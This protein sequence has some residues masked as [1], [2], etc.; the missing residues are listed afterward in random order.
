[1]REQKGISRKDITY[2][3]HNSDHGLVIRKNNKII[4]IPVPFN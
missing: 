1:M 3:L 2:H 4:V